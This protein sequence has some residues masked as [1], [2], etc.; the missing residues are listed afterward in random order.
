M[1]L[2]RARTRPDDFTHDAEKLQFGKLNS[3]PARDKRLVLRDFETRP[4]RND[5]LLA[6]PTL[7]GSE[8]WYRDSHDRIATVVLWGGEEFYDDTQCEVYVHIYVRIYAE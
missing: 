5:L 3:Q 4:N 1:A 8:P 7:R 2:S 6:S